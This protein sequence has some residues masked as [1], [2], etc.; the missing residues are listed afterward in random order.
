[1]RPSRNASRYGFSAALRAKAVHPLKRLSASDSTKP[2][3][4]S[5]FMFIGFLRAM[6]RMNRG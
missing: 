1:M 5:R 2:S 4:I 6:I 3:G